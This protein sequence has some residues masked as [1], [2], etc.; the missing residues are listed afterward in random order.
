MYKNK[1]WYFFFVIIPG[2]YYLPLLNKKNNL[3]ENEEG[4]IHH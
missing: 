3:N 2:I 1:L 4:I